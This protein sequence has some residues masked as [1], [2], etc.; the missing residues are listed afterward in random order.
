MVETKDQSYWESL[1]RKGEIES[2]ISN[3]VGD[4]M[5]IY[6]KTDPK[7]IFNTNSTSFSFT[8]IFTQKLHEKLDNILIQY[9]EIT[10]KEANQRKAKYLDQIHEY[11]FRIHIKKVECEITFDAF[12]LLKLVIGLESIVDE[13]QFKS[14]DEGIFIE[15]MDP[16]RIC[17]IRIKLADPSYKFISEGKCCLNIGDLKKVLFCESNDKSSAKLEFGSEKLYITIH[18]Q[19]FDSTITRTLE[20]L[21]LE[22]EDIPLEML[23]NIHY[24]FTFSLDRDKFLYTMKNVGKYSEIVKITTDNT[25]AD[26]A[27]IFREAGQIGTGEVNW[28]RSNLGSFEYHKGLLENKLQQVDNEKSKEIIENILSEQK[29]TSA[30]S[31]TFLAW[32]NNLVKIL[33]KND[34]IQFSIREDHPMKV[35]MQFNK[36]GNSSLEYFLAPRATR[37][38]NVDDDE[39]LD[40]F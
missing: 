13:G 3:Q 7:I 21:D 22:L 25:N 5:K 12:S 31:L 1:S 2:E 8:D 39:E 28:K 40:D 35:A 17:L 11:L 32:L 4:L 24:P 34:T 19:K 16:S 29:C 30:H 38:E 14:S 15:I 37:N 36:L 10:P 9:P 27:V 18:S 23:K 6:A 20:H 26:K 33:E